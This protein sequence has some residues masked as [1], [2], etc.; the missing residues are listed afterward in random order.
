M[1]L[2]MPLSWLYDA[3]MEFS[4]ALGMVMSKIVMTLFWVVGFGIYGIIRK[5][6]LLFVG[7]AVA[8]ETFWI[9]VPPTKA[10]DLHH[11]F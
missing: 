1:K 4:R 8:P 10:D 9:D 7:K 6:S 11:Q 3:W 2:P 5:I